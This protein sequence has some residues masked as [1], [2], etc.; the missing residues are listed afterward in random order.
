MA[1][2]REGKN[3]SYFLRLEQRQTFSLLIL[4]ETYKEL[5]FS[6]LHPDVSLLV[7]ELS[8][9]CPFIVF[10]SYAKGTAKKDSDLD[11]VAFT[12]K[13]E[14]VK[15]ILEKYPI[16]THVQYASFSQFARLLREKQPLAQEI[17]RHH[18]LIGRKEEIISSFISFTKP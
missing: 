13:R 5:Q 15:Q 3:K 18:V 2:A 17:R 12:S 8:L 14:Q 11:V 10:G 6:L 9:L 16:A 1:Y 7:E 4:L